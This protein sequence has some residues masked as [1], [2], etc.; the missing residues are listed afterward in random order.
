[1]CRE[2]EKWQYQ[3]HVTIRVTNGNLQN[4]NLGD[5]FADVEEVR[6]KEYM[7][8]GFNGGVSSAVYCNF[9]LQ[10][11]RHMITN[12][13]NQRGFLLMVDVLQP[14]T[15][16]DDARGIVKGEMANVNQLKLDITLPNGTVP[17]FTEASFV[18]VLVM[19]KSA[20]EIQSWRMKRAM[21]EGVP[22]I[23]DPAKNY[24]NP[25]GSLIYLKN[26]LS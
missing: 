3:R 23:V 5:K 1:M 8:T 12:N 7:F 20:E 10:G 9:Q 25:A 14:H 21:I 6:L 18:L 11:L 15:V 19:R 16:Y 2:I 22:S 26:F 17:T 13:E 24:Y 4:I